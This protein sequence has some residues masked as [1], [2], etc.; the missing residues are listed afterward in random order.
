SRAAS[1][2]AAPARAAAAANVCPSTRS[3]GNATNIPPSPIS[4]LSNSTVPVTRRPWSWWVRP[5]TIS[6]ISGKLNSI[7]GTLQPCRQGSL[8]LDA[9]DE[10]IHDVVDLLSG[11]MPLARYQH[12]I[13]GTRPTHCLVDR[14][15]TVGDLD[16]L[17]GV[18]SCHTAGT[19]CH[20][21][22]DLGRILA[23]WVV[24]GDDEQ[25]AAACGHLPHH[26]AFHGVPVT[27]AT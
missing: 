22:T 4:R 24:V 9:I 17:G 16:R 1:T 12:D 14:L 10:R 5:P 20:G 19:P 15:P 25:V 11:L 7:T 18:G 2:Q 21:G 27:T 8:Q 23:A 3:P 13:S 26:G 6:A